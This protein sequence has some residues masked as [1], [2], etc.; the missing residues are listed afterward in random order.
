MKRLVSLAAGLALATTAFAQDNP[1][2]NASTTVGGKKVTVDYGRPT[3][4]GRQ[5]DEL[6]K[7]L[8]EDRMWRA[9]ENQVTILNTEGPITIGSK[10]VPAGRYSLY[11][12]APATGDWSIALNSDQGVP[13][14]KI[15]DKAPANMKD[16]PWPHLDDYSKTIAKSEVARVPLKTATGAPAAENFT[17]SFKP[18]GDGA[19]MVLA[20]GDRSWSVDIKPAK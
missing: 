13:L 15:W 3:L 16:Q 10:T 11:V 5:M 20:W 2:G 12:H 9:G 17:V 7:Q 6:L 4:K 14:G 19:T 8:P 18:A 1:R